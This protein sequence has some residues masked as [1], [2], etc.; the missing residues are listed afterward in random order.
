MCLCLVSQLRPVFPYHACSVDSCTFSHLGAIYALGADGASQSILVSNSSFFDLSGGGVKLGK[1]GE[2]GAAPPDPA[3]PV[4]QQD[5][6][7]LVQDNHFYSNTQEFSSAN[8]IFVGYVAD[9]ILAHNTIHDSR[10]S[11]I[12]A[13]WGWGL[14]SYTRNIKVENNSI[15][16][17][18]QVLSDG[19]G[20][21]TNTPCNGCSVSRNYFES[22][23]HVYG[24][25]CT[26]CFV[27]AI[28]LPL[29]LL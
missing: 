7:Y 4:A 12:C 21:Y 20:V 14:T 27:F 22:D 2:R 3:T 6:G 17:I 23:P 29:V 8:P 18:M 5:R 24:C 19:G 28:V 11:G 15:T 10:Y 25:L 26:C 1:S 13:G 9:T 16:K